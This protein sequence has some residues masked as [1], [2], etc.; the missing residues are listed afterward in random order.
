MPSN[1]KK[2][3]MV[4]SC[5]I[6]RLNDIFIVLKVLSTILVSKSKLPLL[7]LAL[8]GLSDFVSVV[9]IPFQIYP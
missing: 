9:L 6:E 3:A 5:R 1:K 2:S 8:K 7:T 4:S